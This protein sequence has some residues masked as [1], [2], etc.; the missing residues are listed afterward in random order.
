MQGN[1]K[2]WE[3]MKW[4]DRE[5]QERKERKKNNKHIVKLCCFI[6][7]RG[8]AT[9]GLACKGNGGNEKKQKGK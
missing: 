5:R 7:L 3:G 8:F 1:E 4:N 9:L 2:E 6:T